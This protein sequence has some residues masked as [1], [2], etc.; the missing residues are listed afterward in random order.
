[1]KPAMEPDTSNKPAIWQ[2]PNV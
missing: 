2:Q 1:M